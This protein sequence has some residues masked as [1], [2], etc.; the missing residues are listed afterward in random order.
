VTR[1]A[2]AT[3]RALWSFYGGKVMRYAGAVVVA[4]AVVTLGHSTPI[5]AAIVGVVAG[6]VAGML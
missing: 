1:R 3:A 6:F 2:I 5:G 4:L